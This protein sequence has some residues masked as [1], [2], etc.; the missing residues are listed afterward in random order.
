MNDNI[1]VVRA[2]QSFPEGRRVGAILLARTGSS[3]G[4]YFATGADGTLTLF[5][6]HLAINGFYAR[7]NS[8]ALPSAGAGQVSVDWESQ[9]FYASASYLQIGTAFDAQLGYFPL[10]G[11]KSE[12][13]AAGYT[14][15]IRND[16]IQQVSIE[17]QVT[18]ARNM[19]DQRIFDRVAVSASAVTLE[20]AQIQVQALPSIEQVYEA[21]PLGSGRV[22]VDPGRYEQLGLAF[23]ATTAPRRRV[24][25][26]IGYLGGDLFAG[27]RRSP[28]ANLALNLGRVTSSVLYRLFVVDYNG[29]RATGHQISA[30]AAYAYTP[31]ARS[32]LMIETN[33]FSSRGLIQFVTAYTFGE[34]STIAL[35]V[36]G[37]SG[38]SLAW[39][40][41]HA[42]G[43]TIR[44]S[45]RS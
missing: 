8:D 22:N 5:K 3:A 14:P 41:P 28:S 18:I 32:T 1:S 25:A 30:Q 17:S 44:T 33:T 35:V 37:V 21:F 7:S 40:S 27:K 13:L 43:T 4:S 23:N 31:L 39:R 19:V 26:G 12:V 34:L 9:D 10:T 6:R 38:S 24:V 15:V 42:I 20:Q 2:S 29:S 16:L 45:A 36:R 11:V